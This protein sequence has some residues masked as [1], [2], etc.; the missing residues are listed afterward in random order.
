ME[1]AFHR[2][3]LWL[4]ALVILGSGFLA[5]WL[6][7]FLVTRMV[8]HPET[9]LVHSLLSP[10]GMIFGLLAVFIIAQ[11]WDG[12]TRAELALEKEASALRMVVLLSSGFPPETE[13]KLKELVR[14]H[15]DVI[16]REEWPAMAR[17]AATLTYAPSSLSESL[18]LVLAFHPVS[19]GGIAAQRE[20]INNIET[21]LDA[22]RQRII[23]SQGRVDSVKWICLFV[24]A[25]CLLIAI[26]MLHTKD[27]LGTWVA[28]TLFVIG[29][30]VSV[31]LIA[32][33]DLPFTGE[34]A[35]RP[36]ILLQVRP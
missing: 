26:A 9:A 2:L 31:L 24:Q 3:P 1:E 36:D 11:V 17:H 12:V 23:L 16:V 25:T 8:K 33:H 10:L 4:M 20:I 15:I 13:D 22:R 5:A 19:P 14:N 29:V 35:I 7:V 6:T 30:S 32:S 28:L 21:A 34:L 18:R 27:R